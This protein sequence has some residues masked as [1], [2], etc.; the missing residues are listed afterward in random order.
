M[1]NDIWCAGKRRVIRED[2]LNESLQVG[3]VDR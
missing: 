1:K 3:T 2:E